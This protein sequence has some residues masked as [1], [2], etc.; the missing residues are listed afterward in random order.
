[1]SG[2]IA[3]RLSLNSNAF[4]AGVSIV[5]QDAIVAALALFPDRRAAR[6][7]PPKVISERID[8]AIRMGIDMGTIAPDRSAARPGLL[9]GAK[10]T[11]P[12]CRPAEKPSSTAGIR[13]GPDGCRSPHDPQYGG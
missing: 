6:G 8:D 3:P 10:L 1:M 2:V 9:P 11:L 5:S 4:R 13:S 12:A 7:L